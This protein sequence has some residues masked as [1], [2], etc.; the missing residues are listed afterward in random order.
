MVKDNNGEVVR[1]QFRQSLESHDNN[2]D[3]IVSANKRDS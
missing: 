3:F 2:L 1:F